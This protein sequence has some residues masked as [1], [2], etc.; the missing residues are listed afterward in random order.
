MDET[1][2]GARSPARR[3]EALALGLVFSLLYLALAVTF[4]TKAPRLFAELDQAFD[5]DLGSWTIDLARPQGPH[6]RTQVH[7][8][9]VLLLNPLGSALKALLR[10]AG[11]PLAARL[12]AAL[13]C[14]LAGGAAAGAFRVLLGRLGV[15]G[16]QAW[17]WTLLFGTSA[18]QL[19]FSS[20]PESYAFSAL[21]LVLV[22]A[23]A[24][25]P[26][27]A[28]AC[29]PLAACRLVAGVLSFGVT[30]TNLVAVAIAAA[31][32]SGSRRLGGLV[33]RSASESGAVLLITAALA[34]VQRAVFPTAQLF[35]LPRPVASGYSESLFIPSTAAAALE[36]LAAVASHV[37]FAGL[38]AP[39]LLVETSGAR[40]IVVDFAPVALLEPTVVS[41]LHWLLWAAVLVHAG[42][43]LA[44]S[45]P[46]PIVLG[47]A[48]W[49]GF[50]CVLHLCFGTSLFLY[51]GH[52]VFAV[53][54]LAAV[55]S[56]ARPEG[57]GRVLTAVLAVLL[58][59]QLL[60]NG[61]VVREI[62]R[63]FAERG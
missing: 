35:F 45:R 31:A 61:S 6:E 9:S 4:F 1:T 44:C 49:L 19:V 40:R 8:I 12:A 54:A 3:R 47:L 20:L 10:A 34:L 42:R 15:G 55:G 17:L 16:G 11:I 48:G 5:A 33:R 41:L 46:R 30:A 51:S 26:A 13:L 63:L 56:A 58:A 14:A 53:V 37:L 21:S 36:R 18:S 7:P 32:A 52:W 50:V 27:P 43:G 24:A 25:R 38:A 57:G 2:T 28:L 59:L 29:R 60:A 62:L 23:V 39:R 22:F